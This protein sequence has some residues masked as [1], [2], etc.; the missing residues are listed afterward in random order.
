MCVERYNDPGTEA[1][2]LLEKKRANMHVV[3]EALSNSQTYNSIEGKEAQCPFM[4]HTK[5]YLPQP[6]PGR[7]CRPCP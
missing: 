6:R 5:T 4:V 2:W 3:Y 1:G 7:P